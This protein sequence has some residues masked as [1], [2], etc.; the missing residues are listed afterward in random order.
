MKHLTIAG[1]LLAFGAA[2]CAPT[3]PATALAGGDAPA[4]AGVAPVPIENFGKVSD[5]LYRG[6]QPDAKGLA[7]LKAMGVKTV[8]NL[9]NHHEDE[10]V[11]GL[12]FVDLPMHASLDSEPPS[13][14]QVREFL[15]IV[16]DPARQPVFVHCAHG[17]DRTGTMCAVYRM[18]V[19]G[20][21]N[22]RAFEE[23][24]TFG[25]HDWYTDLE[26]YVRDYRASTPR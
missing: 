13:P 5:A 9:R 4:A 22:D 14:E 2:S 19:D 24:Q 1:L 23:M 17:K 11:Q 26:R 15:A 7:A 6:A 3:L 18:E 8:V 20:W 16:R 12:E 25:F 21:T 10:R